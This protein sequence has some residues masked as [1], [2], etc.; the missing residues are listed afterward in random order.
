MADPVV[1]IFDAL[2]ECLDSDRRQLIEILCDLQQNIGCDTGTSTVKALVTS[3]PYDN[4][5]RWFER[6][7]AQWPNIRLRG[8]DENDKIHREINLVI[9]QHVQDLATEFD[10]PA[11][12]QQHL[13]Q[14]LLNMQH[15]TYLWLHLAMDEIREMCRNSFLTESLQIESL[16]S[17][18]EDAY[19]RML[20]K[21]SSK[22]RNLARQ[23]LLIVV[24]ARRPLAIDEMAL[25][26]VAIRAN[27]QDQQK[28]RQVDMKRL[29][30]Q[31]RE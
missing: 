11:A 28:L 9:D 4:V 3:R 18:V 10:L 23:V 21:I 22:Q 26:L 24:G 27:G 1:C 16:P 6:T 14:Q 13:R 5:Q 30:K 8:E 25:A 7:I 12:E 29:E 19:E 15:R 31:I 2:D 20:G 17:S